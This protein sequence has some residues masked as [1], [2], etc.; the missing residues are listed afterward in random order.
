MESIK[1]EGLTVPILCDH[2][3]S[4][5]SPLKLNPPTSPFKTHPLKACEKFILIS[6]YF[7][8]PQTV[9]YGFAA[10]SKLPNPLP[11][12]KIAAQNPPKLLFRIQGQATKDPIPYKQRPQMKVAL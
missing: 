12:I 8:G 4:A 10:V 5:Q 9:I 11:I 7:G 6:L 2:N 3:R 1:R